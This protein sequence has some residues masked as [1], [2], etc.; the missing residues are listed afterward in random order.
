MLG[1]GSIFLTPPKNSV[2]WTR[3]NLACLDDPVF[4][5][6]IQYMTPPR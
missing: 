2:P 1:P 5:W 6:I 4:C 3:L